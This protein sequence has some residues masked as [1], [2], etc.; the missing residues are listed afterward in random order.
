MRWRERSL[1]NSETLTNLEFLGLNV[2][3]RLTGPLPD[4]L[5]RLSK[6]RTLNIE[7]T[8]LCAPADPEF[9]AWVEELEEF[10]GVTCP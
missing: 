2:N 6:L 5:T 8:A 1:P 9:L 3:W 4:S 10:R 7:R